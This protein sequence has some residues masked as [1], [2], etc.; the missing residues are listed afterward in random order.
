[1]EGLVTFLAEM[2]FWY[3]WVFALALLTIELLTG[4]TYFFW[5]AIAALAAGLIDLWPLDGAWQIQLIVFSAVTIVLAIFAP[6][7]VKPWLHR[8][9]TDHMTLNERGAQ[10]I[11]RRVNVETAFENGAGKVRV[12]DTL[13]LAESEKGEN[14]AAGVMVE[15]TRAEGTKLFVKAAV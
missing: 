4:S 12:G 9:Q 11:G 1:M 6:P 15:I 14:F 7:Y 13:W 10:K 5:P 8:T 3:W 2:P